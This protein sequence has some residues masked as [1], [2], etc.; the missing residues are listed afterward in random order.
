MTWRYQ[1]RI[2]HR[3]KYQEERRWH[4]V[5]LCRNSNRDAAASAAA[6]AIISYRQRGN[7]WQRRG[8]NI[9][10]NNVAEGLYQ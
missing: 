2:N 9:N 6:V 4:L 8:G 1:R 3:R 7:A 10:R 5:I